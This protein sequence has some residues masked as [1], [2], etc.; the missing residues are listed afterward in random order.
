MRGVDVAARDRVADS[1]RRR[2]LG[3]QP[4]LDVPE[5]AVPHVGDPAHD[6]E[7]V[8]VHAFGSA[9]VSTGGPRR[10]EGRRAIEIT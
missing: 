5:R 9:P 4:V 3:A 8:P 2:R 7:A 10:V 6:R 1:D